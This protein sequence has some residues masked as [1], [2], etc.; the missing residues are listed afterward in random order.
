MYKREDLFG[1]VLLWEVDLHRMSHDLCV[2]SVAVNR[3]TAVFYM[4]G[5]NFEND[6]RMARKIAEARG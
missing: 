1:A 3:N 2:C 5:G 6:D 4:F